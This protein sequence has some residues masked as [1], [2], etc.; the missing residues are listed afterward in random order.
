MNACPLRSGVQRYHTL[1]A[2]EAQYGF[3][4]LSRVDAATVP[5]MLLVAEV[6]PSALAKSSFAGSASGVTAIVP[7]SSTGPSLLVFVPSP[8]SPKRFHPQHFTAPLVESA[9]PW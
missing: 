6:S 8:S 4:P 5:T 1:P 9:H 2:K 7:G 3:S